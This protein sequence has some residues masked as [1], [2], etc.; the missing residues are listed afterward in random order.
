LGL[1]ALTAAKDKGLVTR[2]TWEGLVNAAVYSIADANI[3]AALIAKGCAEC[4][5]KDVFG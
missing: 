2:D 5:T 3:L 4:L 1:A